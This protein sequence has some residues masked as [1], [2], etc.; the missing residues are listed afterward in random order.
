M[1]KA[2][3][4]WPDFLTNNEGISGIADLFCEEATLTLH[5]IFTSSEY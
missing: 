3:I 5:N 2:N 4:K 1:K